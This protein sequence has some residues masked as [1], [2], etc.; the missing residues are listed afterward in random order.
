MR[1]VLK[2]PNRVNSSFCCDEP[3]KS[4][5]TSG[6][7]NWTHERQTQTTNRWRPPHL[8]KNPEER[9]G[10]D[11]KNILLLSISRYTS[12]FGDVETTKRIG[13][14]AKRAKPIAEEA[15]VSQDLCESTGC[16]K[17]YVSDGH[18]NKHL[19]NLGVSH[20]VKW[21]L[22]NGDEEI[23]EDVIVMGKCNAF[24]SKTMRYLG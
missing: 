7:H 3:F 15:P 6:E 13:K 21:R 12:D 20:S 19:F 9:E 8:M 14:N 1:P 17:R 10:G 23:A 5:S 11:W 24:H 16:D 22:C 4:F 18:F 2:L